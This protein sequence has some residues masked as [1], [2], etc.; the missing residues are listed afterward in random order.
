[1][2]TQEDTRARIY[3]F[4]DSVAFTVGDS[5]THYVSADLALS[6]AAELIRFAH[7]IQHGPRF[8][9]SKLGTVTIEKDGES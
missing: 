9:E 4:R 2:S 6:L 8:S 3:R 7:D 1:M 5:R